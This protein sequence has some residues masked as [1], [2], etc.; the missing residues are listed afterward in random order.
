MSMN[1]CYQCGDVYDTDY[2]MEEIAGE[3]VCD[4]CFE[5]WEEKQE[6]AVL[7]PNDK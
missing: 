1:T 6:D 2:Q 4:N 5:D 3:M 7:S